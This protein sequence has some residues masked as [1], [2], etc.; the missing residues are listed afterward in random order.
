MTVHEFEENGHF[1]DPDSPQ[2]P[3][4]SH[5]LTPTLAIV[6]CK[7]Y[8]DYDPV[9]NIIHDP[10]TPIYS[11]EVIDLNDFSVD[12]ENM[13]EVARTLEAHLDECEVVSFVLVRGFKLEEVKLLQ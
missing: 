10:D 2:T 8:T 12:E 6:L 1:F 9:P 11:Q 7:S 5:T 13:D 4:H 3:G